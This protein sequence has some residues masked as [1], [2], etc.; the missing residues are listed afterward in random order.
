MSLPVPFRNY[1]PKFY[2]GDPAIEAMCA[3]IDSHLETWRS[4]IDGVKTL[5]DPVLI[6]ATLLVELGHELAAD[7]SIGDT[8]AAQRY[9]TATAVRGHKLRG[10]WVEDAQ[11]RI[12]DITGLDAELIMFGPN[13]P[14]WILIGDITSPPTAA[15]S[16]LG[17]DGIYESGLLLGG[18][19]SEIYETGVIQIDLKTSTLTADEVT[20]LR[21]SLT[22]IVPCYYRIFLGYISGGIFVAYPGG[23]IGG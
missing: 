7:F 11:L 15:W 3:R 20:L 1:V 2:Q 22:L 12:K 13:T 14:A 21:E 10:L 16:L 23:Q 6:P 9:K 18:N 8:V 19:G 5:R 17:G 4:E